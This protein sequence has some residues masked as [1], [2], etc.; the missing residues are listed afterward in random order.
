MICQNN[1][2]VEKAGVWVPKLD[3]NVPARLSPKKSPGN[4]PLLL[5]VP[6]RYLLAVIASS[7]LPPIVPTWSKWRKT[8]HGAPTLLEKNVP[9]E[10]AEKLRSEL[11]SWRTWCRGEY[12]G[13]CARAGDPEPLLSETPS[14]NSD[15]KNDA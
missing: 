9:I 4:V 15:A 3:L 1:D 10:E 5:K 7:V 6:L 13:D 2:Q 11:T 14:V 12:T 8:A